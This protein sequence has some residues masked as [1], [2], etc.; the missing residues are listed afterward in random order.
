[1]NLQEE[2]I[3]LIKEYFES[4]GIC[5]F[6]K[7]DLQR[8]L[9]DF[10]N[11]E[12]KLVKPIKRVVHKSDILKSRNIPSQYSQALLYIEKKI[13]QG[14][15]ITFHQS[16]KSLDP[17]DTDDLLN[18]WVIHHL[19]LS[20]NISEKDEPFYDRSDYLLFVTF[21]DNQAFFIDARKHKEQNVFAK[22]EFLEI[23]DNNWPQLLKV[24][25]HVDAEFLNN[26]Y[27][28]EEIKILRRK[29][30]S[31]TT[32]QVNGKFIINPGIGITTSGHNIHTVQRANEVC[33]YLFDSLQEVEK[34]IIEMKNA[35]SIYVG[36]EIEEL[37]L[38]I[39]RLNT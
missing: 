4:I 17:S 31:I 29:G 2:V 33:R 10:M 25:S 23:I 30:Y 20:Q 7:N 24:H 26:G 28:D 14:E 13:L 39:H 22:Q 8:C 12:M 9:V 38:C 37:D 36:F 11:L 3:K 1:M 18:A 35:L 16:R 32:T 34:D 5:Y 21:R 19:H 15:D 27:S 6:P